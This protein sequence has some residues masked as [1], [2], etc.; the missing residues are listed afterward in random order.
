MTNQTQFQQDVE[1]LLNRLNIPPLSERWQDATGGTPIQEPLAY[2]IRNSP[3]MVNIVWL[4]NEF[5]KD[6]TWLPK[7]NLSLINVALLSS[8]A[9]MEVRTQEGAAQQMG[10][11]VSGDFVVRVFAGGTENSLIWVASTP[12]EKQALREFFRHVSRA[13]EHA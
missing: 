10:L 6:V 3:D 2:W 5:L 9:M 12:E 11:P 13:L 1:D 8:I 4:T 7:Q